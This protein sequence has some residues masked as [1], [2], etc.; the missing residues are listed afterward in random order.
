MHYQE[1]KYRM[2]DMPGREAAHQCDAIAITLQRMSKLTWTD[3]KGFEWPRWVGFELQKCHMKAVLDDADETMDEDDSAPKKK[4]K[5][6]TDKDNATKRK[7]RPSPPAP[8]PEWLESLCSNEGSGQ[9]FAPVGDRRGVRYTFDQLAKIVRSIKSWC[10][11]NNARLPAVEALPITMGLHAEAEA[12]AAKDAINA[13]LRLFNLA[14]KEVK[15]AMTRGKKTT[16]LEKERDER[17]DALDAAREKYATAMEDYEASKET[18]PARRKPKKAEKIE[19]D[20]DDDDDVVEVEPPK[21][22]IKGKGKAKPR[23]VE[24]DTDM[25]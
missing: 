18:L 6:K 1:R 25:D 11:N 7:R 3:E 4:S 9:D 5:A 12:K 19:D 20:G 23:F 15:D 14:D 8:V 2:K 24:S 10:I 21:K 22:D 13:P 16:R 17:E